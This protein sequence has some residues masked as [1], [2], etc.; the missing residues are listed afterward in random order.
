MT[1]SAKLNPKDDEWTMLELDATESAPAL[2]WSMTFPDEMQLGQNILT[3]W[4]G[5][6]LRYEEH[7]GPKF[8]NR[9]PAFMIYETTTLEEFKKAVER[10]I[11]MSGDEHHI[12]IESFKQDG[13][14]LD[15]VTGS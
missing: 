10:E 12:Y 6:V 13:C 11:N 8:R 5:L 7:W 14:W 3:K 15:I 2:I 9:P 4:P 1:K